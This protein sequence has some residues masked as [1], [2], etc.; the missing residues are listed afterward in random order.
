MTGGSRAEH[1]ARR[2]LYVPRTGRPLVRSPARGPLTAEQGACRPP[3]GGPRFPSAPP[4][5]WPS[6]LLRAS[7]AERG[8]FALSPAPRS[9]VLVAASAVGGAR[10]P[11]FRFECFKDGVAN[12]PLNSRREGTVS[13][14]GRT[15]PRDA[16]AGS[17]GPARH[18]SARLGRHGSAWLVSLSSLPLFCHRALRSSDHEQSTYVVD[19]IF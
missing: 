18:G 5:P 10:S 4:R 6:R 14:A 16:P 11:V 12:R 17:G 15:A 2:L 8:R 3:R 7:P 1:T 19:P 9:G 13:A